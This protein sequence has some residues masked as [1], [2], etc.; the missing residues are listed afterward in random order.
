MLV[1]CTMLDRRAAV[2]GSC[3]VAAELLL[4]RS[5]LLIAARRHRL[6][7]VDRGRGC[8]GRRAALIAREQ[9]LLAQLREAQA[10]LAERS[11]AEERNRIARD[12]HDVIAHTLTVSLLHISSARLAVSSTTPATPTERWPK[13]NGWGARA[14]TRSARSSG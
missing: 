10:G 11:R 12:L 9:Q 6:G 3:S 14:S 8:V 13:P 4:A 7:S 2:G 1:F 5:N